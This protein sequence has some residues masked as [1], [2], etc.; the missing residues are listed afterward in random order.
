MYHKRKNWEQCKFWSN[1]STKLIRSAKKDF[2]SKAI[3]ENKDTSFLWKHIRSL[4]SQTAQNSLLDELIIDGKT[5]W[6]MNR[7]NTYFA[8]ISDTLKL[9]HQ[10]YPDYTDYDFQKLNDYREK[11]IPNTI[12]FR[13]PAIS[14][15]DLISSIQS[16]DTKR[17]QAWMAFPLGYL[18][19]LPVLQHQHCKIHVLKI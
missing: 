8:N 7:L 3:E 5:V 16:L 12:K 2:F 11:R 17:Q 15:S 14:L 18:K 9:T 4:K 6:S 10:T 1:K 13:I 19:C